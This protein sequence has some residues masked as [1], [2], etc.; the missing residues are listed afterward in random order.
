M[1]PRSRTGQE[2]ARRVSIRRCASQSVEGECVTSILAGIGWDMVGAASAASF[3][4]PLSKVRTWSWET[5]WTVAGLFSWVLLPLLVSI[6]LLPD[7]RSFYAALDSRT[8]FLAF[9]FGAMWGI[10]N[11]SFGLAIRYLGMS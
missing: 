8:V 9:L 5:M 3:Y 1:R 7:F 10:G 2:I 4:V 6:C 11:V